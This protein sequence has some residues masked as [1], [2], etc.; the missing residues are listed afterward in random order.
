MRGDE[1]GDLPGG[2]EVGC[3]EISLIQE[4]PLIFPQKIIIRDAN[5]TAAALPCVFKE[6]AGL[7]PSDPAMGKG[8]FRQIVQTDMPKGEE[9]LAAH[10]SLA[11]TVSLRHKRRAR[12]VRKRPETA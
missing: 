11:D 10:F 9:K 8:P 6:R 4:R 1:L 12:P 2:A 3:R 5:N 7:F